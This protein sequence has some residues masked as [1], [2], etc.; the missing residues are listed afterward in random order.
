MSITNAPVRDARRTRRAIL[1]AATAE[2]SAH[3]FGGAR[4]DAIAKRAGANKRMLYH[5]FGNK[6]DL[7]LSVLE[8]TY[9]GIRRAE[10][11]LNLAHFDPQEGMR[12]LVVFTWEYYLKHP[13]F[14]SLLNTE[15]LLEARHLKR[16][17]RIH[18][19]H[20]PLVSMLA[21][22]IKRGEE[23][24]QFRRGVNPTQLY[25]TIAS[26]GFFYL[27]NRH[28]LA[29]IFGRTLDSRE[30]LAVRRDHI[31]DVVLGYLREGPSS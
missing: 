18:D 31:I 17:K 22:L 24:G 19:L 23:T 21:D 30:S 28:T 27:S 6:E 25:I 7:Y 20:G 15:N 13:E 1:A 2:F 12:R 16:S 14:I 11:R 26:L 8:Q 5:Y 4:V 29:T 10:A 9:A 3:G